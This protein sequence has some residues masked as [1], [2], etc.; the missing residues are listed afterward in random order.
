[1]SRR[2]VI[3][4]KTNEVIAKHPSQLSG[5]TSQLNKREES[6]AG[7]T[8]SNSK[9][10]ITRSNRNRRTLEWMEKFLN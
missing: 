1:M 5:Y 3:T 4:R 7:F 6:K 10:A 8:V 2:A 9:L